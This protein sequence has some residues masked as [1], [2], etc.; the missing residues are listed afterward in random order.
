MKSF[1]FSLWRR[2]A[3]RPQHRRPMP[4]TNAMR[5]LPP[6]VQPCSPSQGNK[7]S[8]APV[9]LKV[10]QILFSQHTHT[11]AHSIRKVTFKSFTTVTWESVSISSRHYAKS[12]PLMTRKTPSMSD[13]WRKWRWWLIRFSSLSWVCLRLITCRGQRNENTDVLVAHK[14]AT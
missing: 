3:M 1:L 9:E 11:P 10:N 2:R 6:G 4:S 7:L 8:V 13:E 5:P 12:Y 14:S